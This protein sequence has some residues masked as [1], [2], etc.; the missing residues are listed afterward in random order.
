MRYP[1]KY[2]KE[3]EWIVQYNDVFKALVYMK[4][5]DIRGIILHMNTQI[6]L[7]GSQ[8][9]QK[10]IYLHLSMLYPGGLQMYR[11]G[12]KNENKNKN[13]I[14]AFELYAKNSLFMIE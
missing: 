9:L 5:M 14:L 11:I 7:F 13:D 1:D 4:S 12:C 8:R 6:R 3:M 2:S 10:L